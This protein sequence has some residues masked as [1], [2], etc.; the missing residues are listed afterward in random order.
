MDD[1]RWKRRPGWRGKKMIV[2][3]VIGLAIIFLA[4]AIS[5]F[6]INQLMEATGA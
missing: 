6:V 4:W 3:A 5:S 1:S 2:Q